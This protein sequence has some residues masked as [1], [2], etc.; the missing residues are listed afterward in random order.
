MSEVAQRTVEDATE[1]AT[2]MRLVAFFPEGDEVF[3]DLDKGT[4]LNERVV[5]VLADNGVIIT[6]R[7]ETISRGGNRHLYLRFNKKL[8]VAE[9]I[10]IQAVLGSDSIKEALS[11]IRVLEGSRCAAIALF[12]R[13]IQARRVEKWR[14]NN[15]QAI[16][17]DAGLPKKAAGVQPFPSGDE[18]LHAGVI[19]DATEQVNKL[20]AEYIDEGDN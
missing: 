20:W 12:E 8:D 4:E 18:K 14:D 3:I 15:T 9:T 6:G 11:L 7:L 1:I 5:Q 17:P 16:N 10:A 13:P 2:S 19:Y